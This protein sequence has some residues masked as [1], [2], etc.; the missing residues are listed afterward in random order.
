M[1]DSNADKTVKTIWIN[2]RFMDRPITG[3]ERVAHELIGTLAH[4]H[5][6]ADGCWSDGNERFRFKLIA[7]SSS[8]APAPWPNLPLRRAGLFTGHA[9]EQFDLPRLTR[10]EWLLSLCNTGP[11]LKRQHFIFLH[12]AQPF[13]IPRNF[14]LMFRL[15]YK[16]LFTVAGR[17]A[18]RVLVNSRFTMTE[19]HQYLGIDPE[20]M[21]LCYPGSEHARRVRGDRSVLGRHQLPDRPFVLAVSSANPNKNFG[22][23][24]AALKLLADDAPPCVIVGGQGQKHFGA[25]AL[26]ATQVMHLGYVCDQ[27]LLALYR[28][29]LCLV[30][31]SYYEGFGLPPLEAM[32]NCCPVIVSNTSSMPEV[33]GPVAEYCDPD[34]PKSLAKAIRTVSGSRDR[35]AAMIHSGLKRADLFSWKHSGRRLLEAVACVAGAPALEAMPATESLFQ[36]TED[37]PSNS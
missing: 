37:S 27:E 23:V 32:A 20:K 10:G 15:W 2:A 6:D 11:L 13:A 34:D 24:L 3:V 22:A 35:R 17:C 16:V 28:Q 1:P 29:A 18:R 36:A 8:T 31:P 14:S 7:P 5:L 12:D 25:V 9:W 33:A 21:I 19:L 26:D 30:F 4:E